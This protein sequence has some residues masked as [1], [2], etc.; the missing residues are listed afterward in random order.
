MDDDFNTSEAVAELHR[1]ANLIYH[2]ESKL[3]P[4]LRALG[5]ILGLL[6]RNPRDYFQGGI[7]NAKFEPLTATGSGIQYTHEKIAELIAIRANAKTAKDFAK[8]DQVRKELEEIGIV[9]EDGP[10][11]TTWRRA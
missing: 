11:G 5:G 3:A 9:L 4:Q 7:V 10:K 1:L 2:G 8:A 6:Q